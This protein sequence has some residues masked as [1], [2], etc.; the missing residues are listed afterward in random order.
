MSFTLL[1]QTAQEGLLELLQDPERSGQSEKLAAARQLV[2]QLQETVSTLMTVSAEVVPDP[3]ARQALESLLS[4]RRLVSARP[5]V[6]AT[7]LST[8]SASVTRL[9][10]G[11]RATDESLLNLLAFFRKAIE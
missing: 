2:Q 10:K 1:A 5:G 9:L 6:T 3:T 4:R 8:V 11:E 7:E